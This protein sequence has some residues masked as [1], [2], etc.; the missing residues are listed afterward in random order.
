MPQHITNADIVRNCR[1]AIQN[2]TLQA[3]NPG[4]IPSWR[5]KKTKCRC[6]IGASMTDETLEKVDSS[7]GTIASLSGLLWRGLVTFED[8]DENFARD[9]MILHD[10]W[11]TGDVIDLR[12]YHVENWHFFDAHDCLPATRQVFEAWLDLLETL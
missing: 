6:A 11:F 1:A 4:E 12:D 2:G 5:D 10:R 9:T 8:E 7:P 3:L